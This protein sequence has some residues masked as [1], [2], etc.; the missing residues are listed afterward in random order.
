M[1]FGN[2]VVGAAEKQLTSPNGQGAA[3]YY[4]FGIPKVKFDFDGD[5]KADISIFRPIN[6]QWWYQRSLDNAVRASQ[7]GNSTDKPVPADFDG[8]GKTD[9]AIYRPSTGE[10]FVLRSS[11][12]SF[13]CLLKLRTTSG[14]CRRLGICCCVRPLDDAHKETTYLFKPKTQLINGQTHSR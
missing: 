3:Y 4:T 11:N 1:S 5:L 12:L 14:A 7:F 6:G 13:Y 8:D 9:I 2:L 10:W